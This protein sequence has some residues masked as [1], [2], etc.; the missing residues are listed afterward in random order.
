MTDNRS[1]DPDP[2]PDPDL[3]ELVPAFTGASVEERIYA[4]IVQS[5]D[6]WTTSTVAEELECSTDTARKYLE[7]FVELGVCRKHD[8][9][10]AR[11]ERNDDYF[12]WRY[13]TQLAE[14]HTQADLK[15]NVIELRNQLETYRERYGVERPDAVDL[16][17]DLVNLDRDIENV[18]DD[19]TAWAS[20]EDEL[21][22]HDRARQYLTTKTEFSPA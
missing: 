12:E 19:L 5:D 21:R 6:E 18:W 13:V 8:G 3:D 17:D 15:E 10:P 1:S 22:L 11:Y 7:W 16:G 14:S 4:L 9:R 2:T 20:I